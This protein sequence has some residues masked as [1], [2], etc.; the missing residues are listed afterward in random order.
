M[1]HSCY[2]HPRHNHNSELLIVQPEGTGDF[3][4]W[5]CFYRPQTK[6]QGFNIFTC[7]C[8]SFW[9][10]DYWS[11]HGQQAGG[12]HSTG[13][14]FGLL[15]FSYDFSYFYFRNKKLKTV[16]LHFL[17]FKHSKNLRV[18]GANSILMQSLSFQRE[19][20]W[21]CLNQFFPIPDNASALINYNKTCHTIEFREHPRHNL[22]VLCIEDVLYST[23]ADLGGRGRREG[24]PRVQII[25]I[26][27]TFGENLAK[28]YVGAPP[29]G[30]APSPRENPESAAAPLPFCAVPNRKLSWCTPRGCTVHHKWC[31]AQPIGVHKWVLNL[32]MPIVY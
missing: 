11:T 29:G 23:L 3:A 6:L 9:S 21:K 2:L 15:L 25:S 8:L 14:L 27:C 20:V 12:T 17:L 5:C 1:S 24:R 7:V 19:G 31:T 30:L 4:A 26:S 10:G 18:F 22:L 32:C 13:M 16:L 28:S